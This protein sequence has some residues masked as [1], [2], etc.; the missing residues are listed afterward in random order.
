MWDNTYYVAGQF[1]TVAFH[2][3]T[4]IVLIGIVENFEE[5]IE[6]F[7][8][9]F[10]K[11]SFPEWLGFVLILIASYFI[12]WAGDWRFLSFLGYDTVYPELYWFDLLLSAGCIGAGSKKLEK[13]FDL[14]NKIPIA[15]HNMRSAVFTPTRKTAVREDIQAP[16]THTPVSRTE[17]NYSANTDGQYYVD[18][19]FV[20]PDID[21]S[22]GPKI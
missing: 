21:N 9:I 4:L 6:H 3:L 12:A 5:L 8:G 14:I 1:A 19:D 18:E 7:F 17:T 11:K 20:P 15:L 2:F 16:P 22:G 10:I 13:K